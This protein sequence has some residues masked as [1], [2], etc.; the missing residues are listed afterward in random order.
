MPDITSDVLTALRAVLSTVH[1]HHPAHLALFPCAV[2]YESGG[3]EAARAD[4]AAYLHEIEFTVEFW[5]LAPGETHALSVSADAALSALGLRRVYC[6]DLFDES[7]MAHRRVLRY[8]ALCD[9][10]GTLTQ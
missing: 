3:G 4:G 9:E 2:I 7:A 10:N 6:T 1:Y 8:R 5:A